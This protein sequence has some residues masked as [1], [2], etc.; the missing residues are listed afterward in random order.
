M[1]LP[2]IAEALVRALLEEPQQLRLDLERQV[3]DF[4]EKERPA[5]RRLNL[6][7]PIRSPRR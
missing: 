1:T 4:V 5:V 6:A 2:G 3:P 7:D